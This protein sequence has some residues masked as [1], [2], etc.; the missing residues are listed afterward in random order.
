MPSL[1]FRLLA[2]AAPEKNEVRREIENLLALAKTLAPDDLPVFL[3]EL[4]VARVT[5]LARIAAPAAE[6]RPDEL[7]DVD[8][9]SARLHVSRD[10]LYRHHKRLPFARRMGKRLLFSS[11]G[12]DSYLRKAR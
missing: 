3:G 7:L 1:F 4:E 8:E 12:L 2:A 11:A 9:A 10:Y 6:A 5:A